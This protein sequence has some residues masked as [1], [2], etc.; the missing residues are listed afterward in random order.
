M[1]CHISQSQIT[2]SLMKFL[3]EFCSCKQSRIKFNLSCANGIILFR[4]VSDII[5]C[6]GQNL[7]SSINSNSNSNV[8]L[9]YIIECIIKLYKRNKIIFKCNE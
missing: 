1:N 9:K 7:L 8:L 4:K 2:T 5:I 3:A 6:Y